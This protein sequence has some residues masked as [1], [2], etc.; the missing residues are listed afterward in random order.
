MATYYTGTTGDVT[1]K[2]KALKVT[3]WKATE[4]AVEIDTTNVGTAGYFTGTTG[5]K[6]MTWECEAI[7]DGDITY[8]SPPVIQV[9]QSGTISLDVVDS[10]NSIDGTGT[11][12][13]C[14]YTHDL[15]GVF[16]YS[17]KGFM[18]GAYT[19]VTSS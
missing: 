7:Y 3:S 11:V 5:I 19:L 17:L 4:E 12:T 14:D 13:G 2:S 1:F 9:G 16:T 15:N 10:G 6:K 18:T 8:G